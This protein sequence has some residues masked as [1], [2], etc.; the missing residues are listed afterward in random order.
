M[1]RFGRVVDVVGPAR[2]LKLM[3]LYPPYLGA[4]VRVDDVDPELRFVTVS[5][6]LTRWNRNAVGVHFGGSLYSLCDPW[7]MLLLMSRLGR[8][9]TVW[10]KRAVIEFKRPG[11]GRVSARFAVDDA[12]LADLRLELERTGKAAPV[13]S[14]DVV[15]DEGVVVCRVEKLL[16]VRR[17]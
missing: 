4:G 12:W 13:L 9:F 5:M 3:Q 17:A 1:S 6:R 15:D 2:A 7:F 11:R 10:D 16:T 14:A 8:G